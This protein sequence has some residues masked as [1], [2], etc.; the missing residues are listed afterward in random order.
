MSFFL[1][2]PTYMFTRI[3]VWSSPL[4]LV[5]EEQQDWVAVTLSVK[6]STEAVVC[7]FDLIEEFF[8]RR[9]PGMMPST[10]GSWSVE[11]QG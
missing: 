9:G 2:A 1:A 3:C 8:G 5:H 6:M 7:G 11:A 4:W 10:P